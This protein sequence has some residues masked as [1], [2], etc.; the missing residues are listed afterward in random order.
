MKE[1]KEK[2]LKFGNPINEN[3]LKVD[4]F[5]NHQVDANLMNLIGKEF[6]EYY[7]D[8]NITKV[9]TIESSGI[10]PATF[11]ALHLNVPLVIMK[12]TTSKVLSDD[13]VQAT[14]TSYTKGTTFELTMSKKF[15]NKDDNV[16]VIDDFLANGQAAMGAIKLVEKMGANVESI[17]IL[18]EKSFQPGRKEL[19]DAG[20]EVYSLARIKRM[21]K[22]EVEFEE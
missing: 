6:A 18:I 22:G 8:R 21:S 19:I 17:G 13:L 4:S 12:K 7:K 3:V 9:V 1:L 2:I 14:I 15:V 16:V 5:I 11:T 10:A 20:Y